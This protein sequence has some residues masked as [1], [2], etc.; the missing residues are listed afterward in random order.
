MN[1]LSNHSTVL[2]PEQQAIRDRCFH[3]SG[4]FIRFRKEEIEQS[5]PERFEQQVRQYLNRLAVKTRNQELTYDELNKASNRVARAIVEQ[6]GSGAEPIALLLE[7][8]VS[9]VIATLAVLKT[10]KFF[11]MLDFSHPH[12]RLAMGNMEGI[13]EKVSGGGKKGVPYDTISELKGVQQMDR[14]DETRALILVRGE[15]GSLD[16]KATALP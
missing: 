16:L 10:G 2:P 6:R 7:K 3:P 11:V 4:K 14:L 13:T 1:T 15:S 8:G 12:A 9:Q 5:I